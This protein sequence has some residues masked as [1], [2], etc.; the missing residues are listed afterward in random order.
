MK[1]VLLDENTDQA[2]KPL[3]NSDFEIVT[4][5]EQSWQG[6][7]NGE[8]L[9]LAEKEFDVFVTMDKNLEHQQNLGNLD[10]AVVV[11]RAYSNAFVVVRELMP[12]VNEAVRRAVP[13][14]SVHVRN[15]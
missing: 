11:I 5:S 2:L 7:Q 8:L 3:F 4:M 9:R 12:A 10:L 15:N 6:K 1:R 14:V 13:G